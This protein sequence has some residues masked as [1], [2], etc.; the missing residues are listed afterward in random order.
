MWQDA[1][2]EVDLENQISRV[3]LHASSLVVTTV[4]VTAMIESDIGYKTQGLFMKSFVE[5]EA[6]GLI[7]LP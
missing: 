2:V 6:F 4:I 1:V 3:Y 7:N 5:K